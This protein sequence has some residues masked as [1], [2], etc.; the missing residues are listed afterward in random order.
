MTLPWKPI[1][2]AILAL[3]LSGLHLNPAAAQDPLVVP[4][5]PAVVLLNDKVT[6]F[7]ERVSLNETDTAFAEL[8]SGSALAKQTDEIKQLVEQTRTIESKYGKYRSFERVAAKRIGADVVLLKY[9]YKCENYPV[10]WYFTFY[11]DFRR[12]EVAPESNQWT[13]IAVRFDTRLEML[14][15]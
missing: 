11:R 6:Q 2:F 13:L 3:L 12:G 15:F 14:G 1:Q 4:E 5:D 9:L 8:L 10:V 7:L